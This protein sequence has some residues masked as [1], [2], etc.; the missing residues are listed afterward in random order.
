MTASVSN[1]SSTST[2]ISPSTTCQSYVPSKLYGPL[3]KLL[4]S[5]CASLSEWRHKQRTIRDAIQSLC[6]TIS[7]RHSPAI[8][9]YRVV[10]HATSSSALLS[11]A[12]TTTTLPSAF[13]PSSSL[14]RSGAASSC[15]CSRDAF[16][17]ALVTSSSGSVDTAY[18]PE[19]GNRIYYYLRC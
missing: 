17:Y 19:S 5:S 4:S 12:S 14:C 13:N 9:S 15:S 11:A 6:S 8:S 16:F 1:P 10:E 7:S 3:P 2:P 18:T